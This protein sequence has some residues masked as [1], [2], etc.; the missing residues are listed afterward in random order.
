MTALQM[1]VLAALDRWQRDGSISS[2][3]RDVIAALVG[4]ERWSV[5]IELSALMYLGV[6]S[7]VGGVGWTVTTYSARL[8]DVAIVSTLTAAFVWTLYYCFTKASAYAHE[9]VA[10]PTIAF[11]YVLY[12]GCLILAVDVGYIE[13]R[14]H[15][16]GS[17]WDHSLLLS[18]VIFFALA[19]RFDNRLVLS[20]ALSSLG[21]WFGVRVSHVGL[22]FRAS[23]RIYALAYGAFVAA[24]GTALHHAHIKTH[25]LETYLHVAAHVLFIAL[26]S[27][28]AG[29]TWASYL[30]WT[31]ALAA[32]AMVQGVRW[33]RFAFVIYGVVY[34]YAG[35]S[36]ALL[37]DIR[38][39]SAG[40]AYFVVSGS[41]VIVALVLLARRFGREE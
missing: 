4:K 13:S 20:L 16:F 29:A 41:A 26:L 15:P 2:A 12:L 7:L 32:A 14:F 17:D 5:Y 28:V 21:A 39:T 35:I 34:G 8:G 36:L 18:S 3:Q 22:L 25:F 40:L 19:Y 11:D 33:S 1:S 9:Q 38:S 6:V 27:G 31:L 23:L 10:T 37:R 30:P 24:A